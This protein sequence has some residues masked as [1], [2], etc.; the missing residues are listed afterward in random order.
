MRYFTFFILSLILLTGCEEKTQELSPA[1]VVFSKALEAHG[2]DLYDQAAYEFD[3]RNK[4]YTFRNDNGKYI[5]TRKEVKPDTVLLDT[6]KDGEFSRQINGEVVDLSEK[7]VV[8]HT[9]SLNSV[10][11]F[12]TLPYKL[13]DKAVNKE[14]KGTTEIKDKKYDV[15]EVTF[16]QEGG[17]TDHDD[18]YY[19]WINQETNL[20]DYL[21]YNYIVNDG[22]VR[23][24]EANNTRNVA[25]VVFQDYVN[26]K[27]ALGTPLADLP[28]LFEQNELKKL[29]DINTENVKVMK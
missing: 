9:E 18:T 23:F 21:A 1:E 27:A 8:I 25:G 26:Y 2:G 3:F 24:R 7:D 12:V 10:L 14:Y 29:S 22:G 5:Y 4:H 15:L 19:Y 20:I 13:Q 6:L 11:Y 16:D 17:G 28:K